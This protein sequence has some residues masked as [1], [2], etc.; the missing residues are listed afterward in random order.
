M[1][2]ALT[3]TVYNLCVFAVNMACVQLWSCSE[4]PMA[5][6]VAKLCTILASKEGE[7]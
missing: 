3:Y 5:P 6:L 2:L 7:G 1:W 4:L